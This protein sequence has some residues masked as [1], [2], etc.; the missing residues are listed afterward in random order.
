[1]AALET[2]FLGEK[3]E[4]GTRSGGIDTDMRDEMAGFVRVL[5]QVEQGQTRMDRLVLSG[6]SFGDSV[7]SGVSG[8]SL[9]FEQLG[10]L[11]QHFPEAQGGVED[12]MLSACHTLEEDY[13]T[14]DGQQYKDIFP[15]LSTVWGYDGYSPN[16]KQGSP[17]HIRAWER[18]SRGNNPNAVR[19]AARGQGAA[20]GKVYPED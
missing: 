10:E 7:W 20:R 8:N 5:Q 1:M 17:R 11:M 4:D 16:H 12:L 6:H 14:D 13:G 3:G 15:E 18:A 19:R 9:S 2:F